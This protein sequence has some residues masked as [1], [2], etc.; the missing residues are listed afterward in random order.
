MTE[1]TQ[2]KYSVNFSLGSIL[3][4][5]ILMLLPLS[6]VVAVNSTVSWVIYGVC[7]LIFLFLVTLLIIKRLIPALKGEIALELNE[8]GL[9]DYIR[10]ITIDWKDIKDINLKGGRSASTILIELKW[11]SD[12]G[13]QIVIPL[14][15]VKGK[16]AEIYETVMSYFE[17]ACQ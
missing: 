1:T 9:I 7:A 17:P 6:N 12:Y 16:D 8:Q 10:N 13:S 4:M 2:Y 14:R 15:W 3:L 5:I 11:E